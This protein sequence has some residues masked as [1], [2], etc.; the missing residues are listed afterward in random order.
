M[1]CGPDK[2][3]ISAAI[4]PETEGVVEVDV[5]R[6]ADGGGS[7]IIGQATG[8]CEGVPIRGGV[9]YRREHAD[10]SGHDDGTSWATLKPTQTMTAA[11]RAT[12]L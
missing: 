8:D 11:Q 1:G 12:L 4:A 7:R 2:D 6:G 5:A 9:Q 10:K 3:R